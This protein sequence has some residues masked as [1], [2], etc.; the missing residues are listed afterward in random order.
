MENEVEQLLQD[1]GDNIVNVFEQYMKGK[2]VDSMGHDV[3]MNLAFSELKTTL[4]QI[5]EFRSKYLNYEEVEVPEI[6]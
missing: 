5:M 2:W 4:Q 1:V 6:K 3:G